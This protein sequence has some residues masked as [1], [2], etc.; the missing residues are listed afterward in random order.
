MYANLRFP[1]ITQAAQMRPTMAAETAAD[2]H[3]RADRYWDEYIANYD[4]QPP[5][6]EPQSPPPQFP[7]VDFL[8]NETSYIFEIEVPRIAESEISVKVIDR[9]LVIEGEKQV[10]QNGQTVRHGHCEC[11]YGKFRRELPLALDANLGEVSAELLE[12]VLTVAI[13]KMPARPAVSKRIAI[14]AAA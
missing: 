14:Q 9:V 1:H 8:E 4:S 5:A 10:R 6:R 2:W 12:G 13:E 7:P 3:R 11:R